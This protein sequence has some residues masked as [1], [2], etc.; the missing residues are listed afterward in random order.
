MGAALSMGNLRVV[1]VNPSCAIVL[2]VGCEAVGSC[3][4]GGRDAV[5][6]GVV[7]G[8][9]VLLPPVDGVVMISDHL[10]P[11]VE[12]LALEVV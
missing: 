3:V 7:M 4:F 1:T 5:G 9:I 10:E 2:S 8:A 12:Y 11:S 6:C